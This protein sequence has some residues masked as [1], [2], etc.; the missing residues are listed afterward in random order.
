MSRLP[1]MCSPTISKR[2]SIF[3]RCWPPPGRLDSGEQRRM[4]REPRP[5]Q[6]PNLDQTGEAVELQCAP[7]VGDPGPGAPVAEPLICDEA[8]GVAA[9]SRQCQTKRPRN[10]ALRPTRI[11]RMMLAPVAQHH[12]ERPTRLGIL[13]KDRRDREKH[14]AERCRDGVEDIVEAR[15]RP[16]ERT[17]ACRSV[18]D[19][20]VRV[21]AILY[22]KSP[23]RPSSRYQKTGATTP[24]LKFSARLSIA[25]RATPCSSRLI[26]SRPTICRTASRPPANPPVASA[27]AT[28]AT[29][30]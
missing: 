3:R 12:A 28:A 25:A 19:H 14:A 10:C 23:G 2:V 9:G 22:A 29:C 17:V 24:S 7:D 18:A 16:A 4:R 8:F 30:S 11:R 27:A 13:G 15:R 1:S 26:G 5:E 21:L 20:A 6:K